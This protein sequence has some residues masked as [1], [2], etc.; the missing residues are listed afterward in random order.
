M[1]KKVLI[2]AILSIVAV[3]GFSLSPAAVNL[4]TAAV[5]FLPAV[6]P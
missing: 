2:T 6:S 1:D 5:T 4:I 3:L